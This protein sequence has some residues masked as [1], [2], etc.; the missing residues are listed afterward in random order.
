MLRIERGPIVGRFVRTGNG[1]LASARRVDRPEKW[2]HLAAAP[3]NLSR[4]RCLAS[5]RR[6]TVEPCIDPR[7]KVPVAMD[8]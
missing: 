5:K 2:G 8:E 1:A 3:K 6:L 7:T 4:S